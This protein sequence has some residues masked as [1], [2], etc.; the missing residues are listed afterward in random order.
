[1]EIHAGYWDAVLFVVQSR[2]VGVSR[3]QRHFKW[4]Y[5]RSLHIIEQMEKMGVVSE[6]DDGGRRAVLWPEFE[7]SS[8]EE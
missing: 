1:M 2:R 6:M 8:E 7:F 4:G 3:V 5:N